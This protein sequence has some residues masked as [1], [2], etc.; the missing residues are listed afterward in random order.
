MNPQRKLRTQI[1]M[2]V[3]ALQDYVKAGEKKLKFCKFG[4]LIYRIL[5]IP[6]KIQSHTF[7]YLINPHVYDS[8]HPFP[9]G[10]HV[11]CPTVFLL[12]F[13]PPCCVLT[14]SYTQTW[15]LQPSQHGRI[16]YFHT[17][18]TSTHPCPSHLSKPSDFSFSRTDFRKSLSGHVTDCSLDPTRLK[19]S[20]IFSFP[21]LGT[22]NKLAHTENRSLFFKCP[23]KRKLKTILHKV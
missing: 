12:A 3:C 10:L 18:R 23:H 11:M 15:S 13:W 5:F 14:S 1:S 20:I 22:L 2:S 7:P 6:K 4:R 21:S 19:S 8:T 9:P 17:R 16:I